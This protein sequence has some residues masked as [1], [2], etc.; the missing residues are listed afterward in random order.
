MKTI[1]LIFLLL[2]SVSLVAAQSEG[3][4]TWISPYPQ[5]N[6]LYA[7]CVAGN[8]VFFW[9]EQSTI[10]STTDGGDTFIM[11]PPYAPSGDGAWV[12]YQP[13]AFADSLTG[14]LTDIPKGEFRTTDGGVHWTQVVSPYS[15]IEIVTFANSQIGWKF[16]GGGGSYKTTNAGL[17]W[18]YFNTPFQFNQGGFFSHVYALDQNRL[19]VL[20]SG[21][22]GV[23]GVSGVWHSSN[24]GTDWQQVNTGLVMD[25]TVRISNVDLKINASG[26]GMAI[27]YTY[28][29]SIRSFILRTTDFGFS[30][31]RT[32][33]PGVVL[34]SLLTINDSI[35]VVYGNQSASPHHPIQMRSIDFGSSWDFALDPFPGPYYN[36]FYTAEYVPSEQ[37]ILACVSRSIYRSRD[38]G[39]TYSKLTNN[40]DM[41]V[42]EFAIDPKAANGEQL[43]VA[44]SPTYT[45]PDYLLSDD[46]GRTW[47]RR[48]IPTNIGNQIFEVSIADGVI[49]M[50]TGN[51]TLAKSTDKGSTWTRL[52]I[53]YSGIMRALDVLDSTTIVVT[54][55]PGS[56]KLFSTSDGGAQWI[57]TPL[58]NRSWF[59]ELRALPSG[60]VLGCGMLYDT[61]S[62]SGMLFATTDRGFNWHIIEVSREVGHI[63]MSSATT[64]FAVSTYEVYRTSNAGENWALNRSSSNYSTAFSNLA[65]SDSLH[66]LLRESYYFVETSNGGTSWQNTQFYVPSWGPIKRMAY[67][68]RGELLVLTE[69]AGFLRYTGGTGTLPNPHQPSSN[70]TPELFELSQNYPNPFNPSTS[71]TFDLPRRSH[72]KL[73]VYDLLGREVSTPVDEIRGPGRH[74]V[75]FQATHL[76][77]GVYLYRVTADGF[78]QT[79][80]MVLQK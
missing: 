16:G 79:R 6:I 65:F 15:N 70:T 73:I 54:G 1:L 41:I 43:V 12:G 36:Y 40:S 39:L 32:V 24:G 76:A 10:V 61:T 37:V 49:A 26:L 34:R 5:G 68:N 69:S 74:Q 71:I 7:S 59:N 47:V 55:Y 17:T 13:I 64:G 33:V 53:G 22:Q 25:S 18:S 9:G 66:G 44:I 27:G 45:I 56:M 46:G 14:Y 20:K 67:N 23:T 77:S 57:S 48:A 72:A 19:W 50:I 2:S 75:R 60:Q 38:L 31:V 78:V 28:S 35:W 3:G 4:W 29:D 51:S 62:V 21:Y 42:S 58:V 8:K 63:V 30:W 52:S 11:S 80:K